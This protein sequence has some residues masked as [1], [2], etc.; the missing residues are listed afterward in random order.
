MLVRFGQLIV[1]GVEV[2]RVVGTKTK[3]LL[4]FMDPEQTALYIGKKKEKEVSEEYPFVTIKEVI[5]GDDTV[6]NTQLHVMVGSSS[7]NDDLVFRVDT[8][9]SR[10]IIVDVLGRLTKSC[11][12]GKADNVL[13][14]G[15][16]KIRTVGGLSKWSKG[17]FVLDDEINLKCYDAKFTTVVKRTYWM[18]GLR[19][20]M[21][22]VNK[23]NT[24]Q[25]RFD[26][27]K[28]EFH[29]V[30]SSLSHCNDVGVTAWVKAFQQLVQVP[31]DDGSYNEPALDASDM[32][33]LSL[34][35]SEIAFVTGTSGDRSGMLWK[36]AVK[37]GRN[38]Q[39]RQFV[40]TESTFAYYATGKVSD[41]PKGVLLLTG[42]S[43]VK[44]GQGEVD[45]SFIVVTPQ[46]LDPRGRVLQAKVLLVA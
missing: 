27:T 33:P 41:E 38:W 29:P 5:G 11:A 21:R 10:N 39:R 37:S 40:L 42:D 31:P 36:R 4:L 7:R 22:G 8:E 26:D 18:G 30:C 3:K 14:Q 28:L 35:A 46:Q 20:C 6:P 1:E 15:S 9:R 45:H 2:T 43:S 23:P 32:A 19:S 12:A 13:L 44:A 24:F 25:L 17:Y 34:D 16:M